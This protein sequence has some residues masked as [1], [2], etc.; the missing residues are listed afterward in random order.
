MTDGL[1]Q[2][3]NDG[4]D[5]P[6][7]FEPDADQNVRTKHWLAFRDDTKVLLADCLWPEWDASNQVWAGNAADQM[8]A[9]I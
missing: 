8:Y 9:L 3:L 5:V 4:P 7:A 1:Q 6:A 2:I